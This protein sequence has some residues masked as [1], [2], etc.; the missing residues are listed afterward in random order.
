MI[1]FM[2]PDSTLAESNSICKP[3]ISTC[4]I[5]LLDDVAL[6]YSWPSFFSYF[7]QNQWPLPN[8]G[9][10]FYA[11]FMKTSVLPVNTLQTIFYI[12]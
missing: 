2:V 4:L 6:W 3:G 10:D 7:C 8:K 9:G 1:C 12:H 11:G 5:L